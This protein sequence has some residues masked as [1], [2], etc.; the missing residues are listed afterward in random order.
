MIYF[1]GME[2]NNP[3][4][5]Y[6]GK[7]EQGKPSQWKV[8]VPQTK[9]LVSDILFV[10]NLAST[11]T[12]SSFY[13]TSLCGQVLKII[14]CVFNA[15]PDPESAAGGSPGFLAKANLK[16]HEKR[17]LI[18]RILDYIFQ[19]MATEKTQV[20]SA[21]YVLYCTVVILL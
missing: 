3:I 8:S 10:V 4:L 12:F 15:G 1:D 11:V 21:K 9:Q 6:Q 20:W 5:S 13:Q 18:P 16:R 14:L 17:G 19:R 2:T 7:L